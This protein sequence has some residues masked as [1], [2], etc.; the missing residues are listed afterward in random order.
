MQSSW[1]LFAVIGYYVSMY[2]INGIAEI[3]VFADYL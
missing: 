2:Y 3:E 1:C